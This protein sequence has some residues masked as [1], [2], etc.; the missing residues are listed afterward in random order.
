[1]RFPNLPVGQRTVHL[2]NRTGA[3]RAQADRTPG[4]NMEC[5]K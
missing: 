3:S 2:D 4:R 1:M 5:P